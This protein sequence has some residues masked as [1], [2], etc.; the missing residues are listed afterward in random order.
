RS[1]IARPPAS[2][3]EI[4][5]GYGSKP[6]GAGWRENPDDSG[7]PVLPAEFEQVA[8]RHLGAWLFSVF[9]DLWTGVSTPLERHDDPGFVGDVLTI[10]RSPASAAVTSVWRLRFETPEHAQTFVSALA[11]QSTLEVSQIDRDAVV[12]GSTDVAVPATLIEGLAWTLAPE[13][14][15]TD[16]A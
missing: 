7:N 8:T 14:D 16:P 15:S 6:A 1:A 11:A 9:E 3:R 12:V 5:G 10:F 4:L 13:A 2:T